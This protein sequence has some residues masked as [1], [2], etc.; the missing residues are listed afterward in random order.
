MYSRNRSLLLP[1]FALL[2]AIALSF[3]ACNGEPL[4]VELTRENGRELRVK[5][6]ELL[7]DVGEFVAGFCSTSALPAGAAI[8]FITWQRRQDD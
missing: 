4:D 3:A 8:V 2:L 1:L 6:D 7:D 5:V